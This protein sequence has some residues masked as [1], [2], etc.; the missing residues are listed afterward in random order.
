VEYFVNND[1]RGGLQWMFNKYLI[2]IFAICSVLLPSGCSP[3]L[4][5][6]QIIKIVKTD[7]ENDR[8]GEIKIILITHEFGKY[9]VKWE[10]ESNCDGGTEYVN[11]RSGK[12]T[13]GIQFIC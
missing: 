13:H 6:E 10:R 1:K 8:K 9:V 7:V 12:L 4:T 2:I 11:D 5:D 3:K